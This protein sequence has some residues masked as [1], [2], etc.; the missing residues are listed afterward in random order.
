MA[1]KLDDAQITAR[2]VEISKCLVGTQS[3]LVNYDLGTNQTTGDS[4]RL[5]VSIRNRSDKLSRELL[6]GLA[7]A[8][9]ID[10]R[11]AESKI[12][13]MF[14]DFGW[15]KT[16]R[17]GRRMVSLT[18]TIPPTQDV[19]G[20]LGENWRES[21]PTTVE[22]AS[23]E[24]LALLAKR[25]FTKEALT[26]ELG[27]KDSQFET[28]LDYGEQ[29]GY[30]G[31][32]NSDELSKEAIWTPLYWSKNAEEVQSFLRKKSEEEFERIGDFVEQFRKQPGIPSE[33]IDRP[34]TGLLNGGVAHGLFPS[35]ALRDGSGAKHEYL[36]SAT[37]Q[38]GGD[39]TTDIFEKARM[40]VSCLRHGQYH[41]DVTR[42]RSPRLILR[43]LRSDTLKPHSYA[44]T[45]YAILVVHGIVRIEEVAMYYGKSFKVRWI[46]TPENELAAE[47]ADQLLR[48]EEQVLESKEE[49]EAQKV[50][51]D[52][53]FN[54]SAEQRKLKT[55]QKVVAKREYDRIMELVTG[56]EG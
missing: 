7:S 29:A 18:E 49:L 10:F 50:L 32:F 8:L 52:G 54:Y 47:I 1:P 34:N 9:K 42:I 37:A 22:K 38:F 21:Q 3:G 48:G 13:P 46:S 44:I 26:S 24:S 15:T 51:V 25:P 4:A 23:V 6:A 2:C 12:I 43:A 41:A 35:V 39:K 16:K 53:M 40:I 14:D 33:L 20:T 31:R 30:M 36:F 55:A 17:D 45:Q 28:V 56:V 19:L 11:V 27:V 5:A